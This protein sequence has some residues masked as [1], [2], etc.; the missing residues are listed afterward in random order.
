MLFH[1][2]SQHSYDTC[3]SHDKDKQGLQQQALA[4]AE[5]N[6]VKIHF[7]LANR[8]EHTNFMLLE[9]DNLESIDKMFDPILELGQHEITPVLRR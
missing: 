8:M 5:K 9:A 6:G 3:H 4:N 2:T 1:V 7:N